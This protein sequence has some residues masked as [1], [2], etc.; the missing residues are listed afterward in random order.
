MTDVSASDVTVDLQ[1]HA[2]DALHHAIMMLFPDPNPDIFTLDNYQF[3]YKLRTGLK[4]TAIRTIEQSQRINR[5]SG[6]Y[7]RAGLCEFHIGLIYLDAADFRGARQQFAQARHQWSFVHEP[8]A[9][10]LSFVAE[11]VAHHL[12]HHYEAAMACYSKANQS[13]PRL[14]FALPAHYKDKVY[15]S[16]AEYVDRYQTMLRGQMWP[17]ADERAVEEPEADEIEDDEAEKAFPLGKPTPASPTPVPPQ[18]TPVFTNEQPDES[19][20]QKVDS[21]AAPPIINY[22][23]KTTPIPEHQYVGAEYEWFL[24]DKQPKSGFFPLDVQQGGWLLA[25]KEPSL[26]TGELVLVLGREDYRVL[27]GRLITMSPARSRAAPLIY[28]AWLEEIATN[29]PSET[30]L[31]LA[32][33]DAQYHIKISP[34]M[35]QITIPRQDIV[36][37]VVGFWLPVQI[38]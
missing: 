6:N 9:E 15:D 30:N 28:L 8:A 25:H 17:E 26:R 12:S 14:R 36:G 13:L 37:I 24:I 19:A 29:S 7:Q 3:Q 16:L 5:Q 4:K 10:T 23:T 2:V 27:N 22:D 21:I 31:T 18:P 11:G 32:N 35:E 33:T 1:H 34:D 20:P 38:R